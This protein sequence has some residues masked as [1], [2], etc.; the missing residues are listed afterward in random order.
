M[1]TLQI[2]EYYEHSS[3]ARNAVHSIAEHPGYL[4]GTRSQ[5]PN[6]EGYYIQAFFR[7][8]VE[9]PID[10]P[11]MTNLPDGAKLV[12]VPDLLQKWYGF[13]EAN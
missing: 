11:R 9:L 8:P 4:G 7:P 10:H 12:Y 6:G 3:D 1:W 5:R 2:I 13:T